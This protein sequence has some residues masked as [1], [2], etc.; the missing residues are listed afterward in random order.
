MKRYLPL[1]ALVLAAHAPAAWAHATPL[2]YSPEASSV[3]KTVPKQVTIEFSE[4]IDPA[5]SSIEVY[6]ED[7]S[8]ADD[9]SG[10]VSA[11]DP[12]QLATRLR[13]T[14]S[15]TFTVSWQVISADDGHFTKGGFTFS[16]GHSGGT[17]TRTEGVQV[18]HRSDWPDAVTIWLELL[19][20]A[21]GLGCLVLLSVVWRP[22][23]HRGVSDDVRRETGKRLRML[24]MLASLLIF[25]GGVAYLVAGGIELSA[26][27][28]A[29]WMHGFLP[30]LHTVAGR[31][32][33]FRMV[34]GIVF[35]TMLEREL[36]SLLAGGRTGRREQIYYILWCVIAL[37]RAEVSHAAA[38]NFHPEFS[39]FV[40]AVHLFFK[41]LWIGGLVVLVFGYLPAFMKQKDGASMRALLRFS[42]LCVLALTGGG[43]SGVY[44]VWLHLKSIANLTTTHWGGEFLALLSFAALFLFFRLEQQ[45]VSYPALLADD[46]PEIRRKDERSV[47]GMLLL[48]E[49]STGIVVLLF[50]SL[51]IITTP[52]LSEQ[53]YEAQTL[54]TAQATITLSEDPFEEDKMLVTVTRG[55]QAGSGQ[56]IVTLKNQDKGIGP[57]VEKT[58]QRFA[59]GF[60]FQKSDLSPAGTWTVQVTEREP[61][62]FDAV[63][64]FTLRYPDD[65]AAIH[66]QD[67]HRTFD[68][69]AASLA[70]I[71]V[72]ILLLSVVLWRRNRALL[73]QTENRSDDLRLSMPSLPLS[74]LLG[75]AFV[76]FVWFTFGGHDHGSAAFQQ[77]CAAAKGQW[78]EA[79]PMRAS[80]PTT[81]ISL[82]GCTVSA[83]DGVYHFADEREFEF[84]KTQIQGVGTA[85]K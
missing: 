34:L 17:A 6:R 30:F 35:C 44:I 3:V 5:A 15:G 48:F 62:L 55:P 75:A 64:S 24:L 73:R 1:L 46:L 42:D 72:V 14:G 4:R 40:N 58:E 70:G 71:A 84:W 12:Y 78:D 26:D 57:I 74:L 54:K 18:E 67:G 31:S 53:H 81:G 52:P 38:S 16:V 43:V 65:I 82:L 8:R 7:G 21:I 27:Q 9:G 61:K 60:V 66:A 51:L 22:A 80:V 56:L 68:G 20:D 63:G 79:T 85:G 39:I 13:G 77:E 36:P 29:A 10:A 45:L 69:F 2:S 11:D 49:A 83:K 76:A 23:K 41:D 33:V 59:G 25:A 19:G 47:A 50:S 37:L 28:G 32:A